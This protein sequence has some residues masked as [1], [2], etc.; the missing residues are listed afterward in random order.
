M[1]KIMVRLSIKDHDVFG[2][3]GLLCFLLTAGYVLGKVERYAATSI[4]M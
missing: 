4:F 3:N 1:F 2:G